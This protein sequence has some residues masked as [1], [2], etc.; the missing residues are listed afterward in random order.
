MYV[1]DQGRWSAACVV[2]FPVEPSVYGSHGG[3]KLQP[4]QGHVLP[5]CYMLLISYPGLGMVP[6]KILWLQLQLY[7]LLVFH[8]ACVSAKMLLT[9]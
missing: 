6:E 8:I 5:Y 7:S 3:G 9:F 1:D 2:C 4:L